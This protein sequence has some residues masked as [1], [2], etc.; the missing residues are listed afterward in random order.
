MKDWTYEITRCYNWDDVV[1]AVN[2]IK[3]ESD[4]N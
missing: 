4:E 2:K 3:M 1:E